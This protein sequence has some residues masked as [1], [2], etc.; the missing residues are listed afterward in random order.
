MLGEDTYNTLMSRLDTMLK[1]GEGS[2]WAKEANA[3]VPAGTNP[4]DRLEEIA[5]YA[6]ELHVRGG[7][8]GNPLVQWAKDFMS[9]LRTAIIKN[10]SMPKWLKDWA[11]ENVQPADLTRMAMSG[12][13]RAAA[14]TEADLKPNLKATSINVGLTVGMGETAEVLTPEFVRAEIEKLGVKVGRSN[15]VDASYEHQGEIVQENTFVAELDRALTPAEVERLAINTKQQAIPQRVNG[16]GELYGPKASEWGGFSAHEFRELNGQR[17]DAENRESRWRD[18]DAE[19]KA[20]MEE[21]RDPKTTNARRSKIN[22]ELRSARM[23]QR[24]DREVRYQNA[25]GQLFSVGASYGTPREG[26]VSVTAVH[27]SGAQ[28]NVLNSNAYGT[29]IK[30]EE[31]KRLAEPQNADI[32]PRTHFYVDEGNGIR[33]EAGVGSVGHQVQ[34][35][36]LYDIREDAQ[37]FRRLNRNDPSAMERAIMKAGFDGYYAPALANNQG[38]VVV[39]GNH[40]INTDPY[41]KSE[42]RFSMDEEHAAV[43]PPVSDALPNELNVLDL[44]RRPAPSACSR[45]PALRFRTS[46]SRFVVFSSWRRSCPRWSALTPSARSSA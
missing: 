2:N 24:A 17:S 15:V 7:V 9:A 37:G 5:G 6:V 34:L 33:P 20:L 26:A 30:G 39:I 46:M 25:T 43:E 1:A 13:K 32:R 40:S 23:F 10:D 45:R 38:V 19:I 44:G 3:R 41:V 21:H 12:L 8:R 14:K 31:A 42:L 28:R 27:Y 4:Q 29:G 16:I 18:W 35:N 22:E 36:N 11:V